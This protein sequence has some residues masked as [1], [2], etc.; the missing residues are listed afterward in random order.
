MVRNNNTHVSFYPLKLLGILVNC[1]DIL[2]FSMTT[3]SCHWSSKPF[4]GASQEKATYLKCLR[5]QKEVLN[6]F[7]ILFN[8]HNVKTLARLQF[9]IDAIHCLIICGSVM[10]CCYLS[11][12]NIC[13]WS[14]LF[15]VGSRWGWLRDESKWK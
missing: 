4:Y 1:V 9:Q 8:W 14:L 7:F 13:D 5:Q 3:L 6:N 2:Q 10:L 11:F 15:C 12:N